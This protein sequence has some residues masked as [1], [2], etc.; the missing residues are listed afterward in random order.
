MKCEEFWG[1]EKELPEELNTH[2]K[3]CP[4][5]CSEFEAITNGI[6][7]LKEEIEK[8]ELSL[9]QEIRKRLMETLGIKSAFS[10]WIFNWRFGLAITVVFYRL[11]WCLF[12]LFSIK[13][14]H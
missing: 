5:C 2:L 13:G 10:R 14:L 9:R 11:W 7:L 12:H 8:E 3:H 6:S 4:K 1:K